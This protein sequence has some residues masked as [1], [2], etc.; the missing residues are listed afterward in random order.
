MALGYAV[1]F[2]FNGLLSE[3]L[4]SISFLLEMDSIVVYLL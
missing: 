3:D 4:L 1:S 2:L